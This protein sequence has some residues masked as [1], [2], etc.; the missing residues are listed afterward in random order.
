MTDIVIEIRNWLKGSNGQEFSCARGYAQTHDPHCEA[1]LLIA[2]AKEIERQ[3][4]TE[5]EDVGQ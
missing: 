5:Q 1:C 4:A 3:R 2:A